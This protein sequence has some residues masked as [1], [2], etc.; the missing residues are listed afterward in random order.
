MAEGRNVILSVL[1]DLRCQEVVIKS[2]RGPYISANYAQFRIR[3]SDFHRSSAIC[4]KNYP[5]L[6]FDIDLR[7]CRTS[8]AREE[9]KLKKRAILA[10]KISWHHSWHRYK[11]PEN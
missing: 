5:K 9:V 3:G 2:L 6:D 7:K 10:G 1:I 8:R 4:C 11:T